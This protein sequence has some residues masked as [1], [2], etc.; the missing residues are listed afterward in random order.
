MNLIK[1]AAISLA[2]TSMVLAPVAASAA[3]AVR[4]AAAVEAQNELEGSS[5]WIYI[6]LAL[7][8][9]VGIVVLVSDGD[10]KPTSP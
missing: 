3:P 9:V 1:K 4:A 2:A 8:A 7:A 10:D 6:V 5:S